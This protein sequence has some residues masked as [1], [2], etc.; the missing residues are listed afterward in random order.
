MATTFLGFG[1]IVFRLLVVLVRLS[2]K[3]V[4]WKDWSP[5][6]SN[7]LTGSL[8]RILAMAKAHCSELG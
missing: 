6:S 4:D 5:M 3:V 2:V 7:A 8:N 1:Y